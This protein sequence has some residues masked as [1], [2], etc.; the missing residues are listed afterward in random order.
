MHV[1]LHAE[2]YTM[3]ANDANT[4]KLLVVQSQNHVSLDRQ[5][6]QLL[7]MPVEMSSRAAQNVACLYGTK[8]MSERGAFTH[9]L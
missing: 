9:S 2:L 4:V 3:N 7:P 6:G 5:T 1:Q 8:A